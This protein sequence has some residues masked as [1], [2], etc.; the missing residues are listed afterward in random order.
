MLLAIVDETRSCRL[1]I[2]L[3][4][5]PRCEVLVTLFFQR[6]DPMLLHQIFQTPFLF[7]IIIILLTTTTSQKRQKLAHLQIVVVEYLDYSCRN[8]K[9][10]YQELFVLRIK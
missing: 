7:L 8:E 9:K 4:D 1:R 2:Q 6:I 5:G 10:K 3:D